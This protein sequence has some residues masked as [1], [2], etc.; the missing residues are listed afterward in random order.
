MA[1]ARAM[2]DTY[3]RSFNVD[4]G[5]LATAIEAMVDC[6][7]TC[8]QCADVCLS[9]PGLSSGLAKCI[10]LD[11]DCADV[12]AAA[13]RVVARQTGYDENVTR[14]MLEACA[15]VCKSCG[16]ECERHAHHMAHCRICAESCRQCERACRDL[17]AATVK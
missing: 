9:E 8:T 14:A 5:L 10:R 7:T 15:A 11:L 6:A 4:S 2:L 17:L 12:C 1:Q 3:P 16:D 13:A